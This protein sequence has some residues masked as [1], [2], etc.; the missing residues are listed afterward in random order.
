[1]AVP[2]TGGVVDGVSLHLLWDKVFL[3]GI[4]QHRLIS[5]V[6]GALGL[7]IIWGVRSYLTTL[8]YEQVLVKAH[9]PPSSHQSL[10]NKLTL[11]QVTRPTSKNT[12][13]TLTSAKLVSAS[14]TQNTP[15]SQSS[16][17]PSPSSSSSTV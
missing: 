10:E 8:N 13:R 2:V 17:N 4:Q 5:S 16:P 14:S 9:G 11:W 15:S 6:V 7:G 3:R 1:M 12:S